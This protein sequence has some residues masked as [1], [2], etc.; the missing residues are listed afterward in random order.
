M[1]KTNWLKKAEINEFPSLVKE[2]VLTAMKNNR[3]RKVKFE[4][5]TQSETF[6]LG[7][8]HRYSFFYG[9]SEA[10]IK[11]QSMDTLCG[12]GHPTS[13]RVNERVSLPQGTWVVDVQHFLG[14]TYI[15]VYNVGVDQ[16]S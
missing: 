12:G 2:K 5:R 10:T 7:E 13:Y 16:I 14:D 6:Y 15:T 11:M 9:D 1:V 8:G 4:A 3:T